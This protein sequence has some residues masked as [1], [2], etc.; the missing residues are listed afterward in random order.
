MDTDTYLRLSDSIGLLSGNLL[1]GALGIPT[2]LADHY[3][4]LLAK[5]HP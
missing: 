5:S 1:E 3:A 2:L 4:N